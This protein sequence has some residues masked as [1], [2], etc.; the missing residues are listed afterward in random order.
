MLI[1]LSYRYRGKIPR[2]HRKAR[3]TSEVLIV[4]HILSPPRNRIEVIVLRKIIIPYSQMKIRE[5][6][7]P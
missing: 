6:S 3:Q 1:N 4:I 5:N 2:I 7:P